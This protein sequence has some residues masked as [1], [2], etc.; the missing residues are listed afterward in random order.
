[1]LARLCSL[2][3]LG[4]GGLSPHTPLVTRQGS[5]PWSCWHHSQPSETS[6][7][8]F[9]FMGLVSRFECEISATVYAVS[10]WS[11]ASTCFQEAE[12]FVGWSRILGTELSLR[13]IGQACFPLQYCAFWST[14]MGASSLILQLPQT[15]DIFTTMPSLT[16]LSHQVFLGPVILSHEPEIPALLSYICYCVIATTKM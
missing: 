11:L 4:L 10:T 16:R 3:K 1:M 6:I 14:E 2:Y 8:P 12:G 7:W 5:L 15:R 13:V 9:C